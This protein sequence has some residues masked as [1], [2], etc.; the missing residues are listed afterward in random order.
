MNIIDWQTARSEMLIDQESVNLNCGSFGHTPRKVWNECQKLRHELASRPMNFFLRTTPHLLPIARKALSKNIE[1]DPE[2]LIFFPN[3]TTSINLVAKSWNLATGDIILTTDLE[4]G[5]MRWV[6]DKVVERTG[7]SIQIIEMPHL[8]ENPNDIVAS[9]EPYLRH[10]V[11]LIFFSHV[12]SP[13]GMVLPARE[14]CQLADNRGIATIVDGAHAVGTLELSLRDIQ[15]NCYGSNLHKW[16]GAPTGSA[17]LACK[18]E[19]LEC[20][21]P[22][23]VSWGY[24]KS[25]NFPQNADDGLGSTQNIRKLEFVGTI[26]PCPWLVTPHAIEF[27]NKLGLKNIINRQRDLVQYTRNRLALIDWLIPATPKSAETS[28]SMVAFQVKLPIR[29]D[30]MRTF[31]WENHHLEIG[32]NQHSRLGLLLRVS[33]HFFTEESEIEHLAKALINLEQWVSECSNQKLMTES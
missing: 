9:V 4:Y 26:D 25:S 11:K 1:W 24:H 27:Q 20:L 15:A 23:I 29:L 16:L 5:A 7:C 19:T 30:F 2:N 22:L 10:P 32:L 28:C 14:L 31:L 33:C 21:E 13:T 6:W 18:A 3:V 8:C 12:T 17:F